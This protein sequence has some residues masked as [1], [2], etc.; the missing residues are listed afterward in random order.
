MTGH[1]LKVYAFAQSHAQNYSRKYYM[2]GLVE[3]QLGRG[4][5]GRKLME[6]GGQGVHV[7]C[8]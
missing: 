1:G 4:K 3:G 7:V 6:R 8:L 5:T 2:I